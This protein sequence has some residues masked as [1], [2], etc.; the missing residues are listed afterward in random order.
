MTRSIAFLT[1]FENPG[2][3]IAMCPLLHHARQERIVPCKTKSLLV[4]V[5]KHV[6]WEHVLQ[7]SR[8]TSHRGWNIFANGGKELDIDILGVSNCPFQ[9]E[10]IQLSLTDITYLLINALMSS[11][12]SLDHSLF[13]QGCCP[14]DTVESV[15][16]M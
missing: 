10:M 7:Y 14:L 8:L 12:V 6:V 2:V 5:V 13:R 3:W 9:L 15:W 4:E 16:F 11:G 1:Y